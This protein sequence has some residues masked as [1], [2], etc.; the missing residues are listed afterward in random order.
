MYQMQKTQLF[1]VNRNF[2]ETT[3][4]KTFFVDEG[5]QH[6]AL[7][8]RVILKVSSS[9]FVEMYGLVS[10]VRHLSGVSFYWPHCF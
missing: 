1:R 8:K 4:T 9:R 2:K 3:A 6:A 7:L 10:F 5:L